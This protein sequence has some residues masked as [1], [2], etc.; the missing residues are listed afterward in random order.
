MDSPQS[1]EGENDLEGVTSNYRFDQEVI[2]EGLKGR[3]MEDKV[4]DV[5][6]S[7]K[8]YYQ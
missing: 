7:P 3:A 5:G 8:N 4:P 2:L 6:L 1:E